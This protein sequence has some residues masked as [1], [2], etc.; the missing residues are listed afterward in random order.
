MKGDPMGHAH[1]VRLP[2]LGQTSDEMQVVRWY[3]KVGDPVAIAEPLLCVETD[4]AQVDVE[5]AESG[6]VLRI[7]AQ[8]GEVLRE[9]DAV[10]FIGQP[11]DHVPSS[12]RGGMTWH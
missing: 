1:E 10:A 9:G 11:G 4:K 5:A 8:E 12:E 7:L 3:K 6:V 2:S